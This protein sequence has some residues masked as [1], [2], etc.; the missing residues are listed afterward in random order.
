MFDEV[1]FFKDLGRII[2]KR[3]ELFKEIDEK[4]KLYIKEKGQP[5]DDIMTEHQLTTEKIR[6]NRS[7]EDEL[8]GEEKDKH[9]IGSFVERLRR[10]KKS[11]AEIKK[12]MEWLKKEL[13]GKEHLIDAVVQKLI[14]RNFLLW[15]DEFIQRVIDFSV[16]FDEQN[17][18]D[19]E[20]AENMGLFETEWRN[21]E[22]EDNDVSEV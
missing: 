20:D 16:C 8:V 19:W 7:Q 1:F 22:E 14:M 2:E 5:Y 15:Q 21:I 6:G 9:F 10:Q 12:E 11:G 18:L 4:V 3:N 17:G 13:A